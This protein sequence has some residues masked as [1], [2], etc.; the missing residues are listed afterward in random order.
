MNNKMKDK[1]DEETDRHLKLFF[2]ISPIIIVNES[3]LGSKSIIVICPENF[4]LIS[5][6]C[7]NVDHKM[8]LVSYVYL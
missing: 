5:F 3:N 8:T 2:G 4:Y 1:K 7:L 6:C